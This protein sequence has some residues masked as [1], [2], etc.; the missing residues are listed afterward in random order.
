MLST[1]S[2]AVMASFSKALDY[3]NSTLRLRYMFCLFILL[4]YS[5]I[6]TSDGNAKNM[7]HIR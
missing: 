4:E 7:A 3:V 2:S 5:K 1:M 6:V